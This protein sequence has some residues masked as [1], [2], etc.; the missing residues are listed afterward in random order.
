M[1]KGWYE[2]TIDEKSRISIPAKFRDILLVKFDENLTVTVSQDG[3]LIV[4]PNRVWQ[5][6]EEK[7]SKL[8][9]FSKAVADFKKLYV[10]AAQDCP[11]DKQGR[12]IIPP[13]LRSYAKLTKDIM[14]VG[15]INVFE[16]WDMASWHAAHGKAKEEINWNALADLGL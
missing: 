1:F 16:I 2:R 6:L 8:P 7:V 15:Q 3:C 4:Y 14:L 9:Q 13:T 11:I 10:S 12:I 5:E